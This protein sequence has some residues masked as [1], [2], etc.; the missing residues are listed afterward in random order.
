V[1][2]I[3]LNYRASDEPFGVQMID[4]TLSAQFGS[5]VVFLASKSIELGADWEREMFE[6]VAK[7]TALLVIMG[8]N[9]LAASDDDGRRR[10]DDPADFVRR[11][12]RLAFELDK[13]VIPVRLAV[14]RL[15]AA[16]LPEDLHALLRCQDIEIRFRSARPDIDLL[17]AKLRSQ[18]QALAGTA[19][20]VAAGPK[21]VINAQ[22]AGTVVTTD[23]FRVDTFHAGP[24]FN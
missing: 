13:Q 21:N 16:D 1:T 24:I 10:L 11:E 2:Q 5:D 18:I 17:V 9:W 7:S 14:P 3:F 4:Q 8:R 20:P 12:I 22:H 23:L 15:T 19:A 6:A